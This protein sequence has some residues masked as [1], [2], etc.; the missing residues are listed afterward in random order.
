MGK[1]LQVINMLFH[2]SYKNK[3]S[4]YH[5]F[6]LKNLNNITK[7]VKKSFVCVICYDRFSTSKAPDRHL[8]I[9][10]VMTKEI[11]PS[12]NKFL[13]FDDN[14][15]AKFTGQLLDLQTLSLSLIV[16]IMLRLSLKKS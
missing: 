11:Y 16:L 8:L 5:Y 12:P 3:K 4:L 7:N 10:N 2:K 6:W 13:T 15:A 9:C 1:G 14:K